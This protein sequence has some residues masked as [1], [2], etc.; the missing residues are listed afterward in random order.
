[1]ICDTFSFSRSPSQQL[2]QP[3]N[4][5]MLEVRLSYAQAVSSLCWC[6]RVESRGAY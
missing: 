3:P 6:G 1:M 4:T 5:S 2:A